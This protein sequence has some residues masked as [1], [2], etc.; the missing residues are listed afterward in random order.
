MGRP[1]STEPFIRLSKNPGTRPVA[2]FQLMCTPMVCN[3]GRLSSAS[4]DSIYRVTDTTQD[5]QQ[6]EQ[7]TRGMQ[8]M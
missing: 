2:G 7:G 3:S 4:S 5:A 1:L 8:S 6:G